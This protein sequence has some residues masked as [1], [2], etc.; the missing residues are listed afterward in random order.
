MLPLS[1][2]GINIKLGLVKVISGK[3]TTSLNAFLHITAIS[4]TIRPHLGNPIL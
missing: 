3:N 2:I 1:L 4:G